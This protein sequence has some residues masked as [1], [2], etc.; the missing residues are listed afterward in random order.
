[1][2]SLLFDTETG[3]VVSDQIFHPVDTP[4]LK[5]THKCVQ[6]WNFA[7]TVYAGAETHRR[8]CEVMKRLMERFPGLNITDTVDYL[9][10]GDMEYL[11]R[12]ASEHVAVVGA[13]SDAF[14]SLTGEQALQRGDRDSRVPP[15]NELVYRRMAPYDLLDTLQQKTLEIP[16]REVL[17]RLGYATIDRNNAVEVVTALDGFIQEYREEIKSAASDEKGQIELV[18]HGLAACFGACVIALFGGYWKKAPKDYWHNSPFILVKVSAARVTVDPFDE[19]VR[20]IYTREDETL[21]QAMDKI[22]FG[23]ESYMATYD[24]VIRV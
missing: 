3:E 6:N 9:V 12:I 23:E 18:Q 13:F 14:E 10:T 7:K 16:M 11:S 17:K 8:V 4:F 21:T 2:L 15:A 22:R 24:D 5:I 20:C 1:V 19:L